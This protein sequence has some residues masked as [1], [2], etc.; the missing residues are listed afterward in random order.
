MKRCMKAML[1]GYTQAL[2]CLLYKLC[3]FMLPFGESA[4][5]IQSG[6]FTIPENSR[7]S[8]QL[9]ALISMFTSFSHSVTVDINSTTSNK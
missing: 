6:Q 5:A 8:S 3:F 2:G 9:I 1:N 4:V 7:Y